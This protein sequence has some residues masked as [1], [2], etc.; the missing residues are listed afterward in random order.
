[1]INNRELQE[2]DAY[3]NRGRTIRKQV[4]RERSIIY[5]AQAIKTQL[6]L[7]ARPTK[8]YDIFSRTPKKSARNLQRTLDLNSGGDN[9]YAT[10]SKFHK[11]THKVYHIGKDM[12]K[13]TRDDIGVA[14]FTKTPIPRPK[15]K[16]INGIHYV[17]LSETIKDKKKALRDKQYEFRHKKDRQDLNIIQSSRRFKKWM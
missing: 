14:D 11:G 13:G 15:T 5:G 1:M 8:D 7:L 16:Q 6:G 2:G 3:H 17:R 12:R 9:Y 10:P 4:R